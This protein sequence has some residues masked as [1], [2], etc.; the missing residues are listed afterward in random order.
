MIVLTLQR[1]PSGVQYIN[2]LTWVAH[3]SNEFRFVTYDRWPDRPATRD[4]IDRLRR[5]LVTQELVNCWPGTEL[6]AG[7]SARLWRFR[8]SPG[9]VE[10][11]LGATTSLADW[12][13]DLPDDP[14]FTREDG[15]VVFGSTSSE[16]DAWLQ[17]TE[18]EFANFSTVPGLEDLRYRQ[19][20]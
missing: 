18:E 7:W 11:L 14:H 10:D 12:G 13:G 20:G 15:T 16:E 9:L 3:L 4:L 1:E 17:L 19:S 8:L 2:L 5:H 6:G